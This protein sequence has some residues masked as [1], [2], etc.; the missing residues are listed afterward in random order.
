MTQVEMCIAEEIFLKAILKILY[1]GGN[2]A[3]C[4]KSHK[5]I[6]CFFL[7]FSTVFLTIDVPV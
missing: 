4:N 1:V 2:P 6:F 3:G 7:R 5:N